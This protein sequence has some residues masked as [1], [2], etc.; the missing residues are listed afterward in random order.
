MTPEESAPEGHAGTPPATASSQPRQL[1][2]SDVTQLTYQ[3]LVAAVEDYAI[4]TLDANG[5]I[6]SWNLGASKMKGYG[7]HEIIGEHF[8]RFYTPAAV[9]SGW[10]D[11]E[12]RVAAAQGRFEDEGWR[13]RKDGSHFWANV[14]ITALRNDAGELIGF[15]KITRDLTERRRAEYA[16]RQ[17]EEVLRLLVEGVKDYAIFMLDPAGNVMSWNAGAASIKGYPRDEVIGRPASIFYTAED[18]AAGRPARELAVARETGRMEYEGWRV[19]KDGT[20]FWASVTI[21][22]VYDDANELRGFAK[23]TRDMSERKRLVELEESSQ[24]MSEFLATLSH[25]LRN[26]LAPVRNAIN[27]LRLEPALS[28]TMAY[29]RDVIDRQIGH[30]TRLVDDLLDVG[31]ITSGKIELRPAS[32]EVAEFVMRGIEAAHVAIQSREQEV[33]VDLPPGPIQLRGDMT[34][35]VQVVQNLLQ[36]ASKFSPVGSTILI[37]GVVEERV[38]L[39]HV[40][41]HGRGISHNALD[42]IFNL[43]VQERRWQDP[44]EGGLGIGLSLCRSLV[45]LHGGSISAHSAGPGHGSTFTVRLPLPLATR[46]GMHAGSKAGAREPISM[47]NVLVVDDNRDSADSLGMLLELKGHQ[48]RIAYDGEAALD[49]A[50][51]FVPHVA[52]IDLAMP[53]IDGFAVMRSLRAK[54]RLSDTLFAAMTGFGQQ[55]DLERTR[56]AGFHCHLVKPLDLPALE[57]VLARAQSGDMPK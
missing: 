41:D 39:L 31:R 43:F 28:T 51:D 30:L 53:I 55:G 1:I 40:T 27:T 6:S 32:V 23:V 42:S 17:S 2:Q 16:L 34:R 13:V 14:I 15:L 11:Y 48:V 3:A 26:P 57:A 38:V 36:N 44:G 33:E 56:Q 9:E 54:P 45:E 37:R 5:Y 47:L 19:R 25:E 50:S 12:L 10:P 49:I 35:L 46:T 8:S 52:L 22:A 4:F 21:T 29:C 24:R 7:E 18:V 20:L